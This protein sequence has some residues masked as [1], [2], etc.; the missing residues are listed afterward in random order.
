VSRIDDL[1]TELCPSGVHFRT[2][3]ELG[4][5]FGGLTGKS[6]AD[7]SEGN[8]RFVSYVNVLN[9]IAVNINAGDFVKVAPGERQR[10]LQRGDILFTG[11]SETINEVAMSSVVTDEVREPLYLNSFTIGYRLHEPEI[12]DPGFSKH[13]FRS[14]P[15]RKQLIRTASG[16]TRFNVSKA[17][18]AD[19]RIPVPPPEIQQEVVSILDNLGALQARLQGELEAE[20]ENRTRQYSYHRDALV[21]SVDATVRWLPMGAVGQ[22]IRGRRFTKSD[23]VEVGIPSIHYGEIYTH[24][25]VAAD[26]VISH[27]R[28]D[29]A[30]RL[31]F[32]EPGDVVIAAVGETVEDVAKAVAWMGDKPVAI[33]DDTFLF[34]SDLHPKFVSYFT[35]SANFH[36]QKNKYVARA[37]V[38][39]LSSEG[40][41][42]ILIPLPTMDYQLQVIGILDR[43]DVLVNDLTIAISAEIL[44]RQLQ[45]EYYRDRLLTFKDAVA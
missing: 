29:L 41:A 45:Y 7:F 15:I 10:S 33:H 42:K 26:S 22:F 19:V 18:L 17:R 39:R 44:A 28:E 6:K 8:A 35:Q 13:L 1:I 25:G 36:R 21:S 24:Y 2:L 34:R 12:L 16:V 11:S 20:A 37:K 43:F 32:A 5:A 27:V 3:G 38:K 23:I 4:V 9:N 30:D 14:A 40:L 31:R